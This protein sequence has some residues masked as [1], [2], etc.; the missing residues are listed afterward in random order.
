MAKPIIERLQVPCEII[1]KR[2]GKKL[3]KKT[4]HASELL[5]NLRGT[6]SNEVTTQLAKAI[7]K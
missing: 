4:F 5:Y 6:L 3:V 7:Y 1:I 2:N